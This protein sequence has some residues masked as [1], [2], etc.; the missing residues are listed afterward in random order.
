MFKYHKNLS[1][2]LQKTKKYSKI[3]FMGSDW[4]NFNNIELSAPVAD[5]VLIWLLLRMCEYNMIYFLFLFECHVIW[6][7]AINIVFF[8][9][10]TY[11]N[12]SIRRSECSI[13]MVLLLLVLF[14]PTFCCLFR[15]KEIEKNTKS[16]E[17]RCDAKTVFVFSIFSILHIAT[18]IASKVNHNMLTLRVFSFIH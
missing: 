5:N 15:K 8:H 9:R 6:P 4:F 11:H 13:A 2:I 7:R 16:V 1:F 17:I 3:V 12:V 18:H 14:F 10:H